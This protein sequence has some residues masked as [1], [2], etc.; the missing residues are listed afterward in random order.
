MEGRRCRAGLGMYA[1]VSEPGPLGPF[2]VPFPSDACALSPF[3]RFTPG[4]SHLHVVGVVTELLDGGQLHTPEGAAQAVQELCSGDGKPEGMKCGGECGL[5]GRGQRILIGPGELPALPNLKMG[6][7]WFL[8]PSPFPV[9]PPYP[10]ESS[11]VGGRPLTK[12]FIMCENTTLPPS[13][14]PPHT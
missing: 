12:P 4:G 13:P 6:G 9:V 2:H 10:T 14:P 11:S 3:L 8:G 7:V 1:E 5:G